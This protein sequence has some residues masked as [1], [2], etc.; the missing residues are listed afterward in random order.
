VTIVTA[1]IIPFRQQARNH[2]LTADDLD[3]L[4]LAAQYLPGQWRMDAA[5]AEVGE[6]C[7]ESGCG[8]EVK[9]GATFCGIGFKRVAGTVWVTTKHSGDGS[10]TSYGT[11]D[12]AILLVCG[13]MLS[14]EAIGPSQR[15]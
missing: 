13:I 7:R 8:R 12:A 3:R 15:P 10:G 9:N 6:I 11:V 4:E 14:D 2:G 5:M 1:F